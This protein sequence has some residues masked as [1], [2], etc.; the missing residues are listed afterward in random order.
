MTK[1]AILCVDDEVLIVMAIKEE[2]KRHFRERF[3]YETAY[4][5]AEGI[6]VIDQLS[7]GGIELILVISDWLMPGMKGDEFLSEVKHRNPGIKTI[8]VTGQASRQALDR[9]KAEGLVNLVILKPWR[10]LELIEKIED[11]LG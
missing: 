11:L 4:S 1:E 3:I 6:E 7:A 5:A 9:I 10:N 8:L 2:I